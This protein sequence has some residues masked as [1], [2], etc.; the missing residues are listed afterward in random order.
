M[1]TPF[2]NF[3]IAL[4]AMGSPLWLDWL[5][6][7]SAGAGLLLPVA[8]LLLAVLQIVRLLKDWRKKGP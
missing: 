7:V 8:G 1:T 5:A 2:T 4:A 3:T 6:K